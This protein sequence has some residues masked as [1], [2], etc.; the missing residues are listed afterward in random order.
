MVKPGRSYPLADQEQPQMDSVNEILADI[1][2]KEGGIST[3]D[4]QEILLDR[5]ENHQNYT[6]L[7]DKSILFVNS[8]GEAGQDVI[9]K[10]YAGQY[11]SMESLRGSGL[12]SSLERGSEKLVMPPHLF[13]L[14]GSAYFHMKMEEKD[15]S[16]FLW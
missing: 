7:G 14:V 6:K 8:G 2:E 12:F 16:I 5:L 10:S 15:Q 4:I 13:S 11:R 9:S 3:T 1:L